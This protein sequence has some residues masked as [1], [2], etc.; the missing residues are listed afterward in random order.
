MSG[1]LPTMKKYSLSPTSNSN[2][3]LDL[4]VKGL[5]IM[6]YFPRG[7][8]GSEYEIISSNDLEGFREPL[9]IGSRI[10]SQ[11]GNTNLQGE[12]IALS[13]RYQT[14]NPYRNNHLMSI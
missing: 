11:Q 1:K 6:V 14:S 2:E 13:G 7:V 10:F 9:N 3:C 5:S 8:P 4:S 12:V